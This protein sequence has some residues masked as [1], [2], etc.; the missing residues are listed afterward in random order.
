MVLY[1]VTALP[2][3][4]VDMSQFGSFNNTPEEDDRRFSVER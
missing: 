3:R 1:G 4:P 2:W